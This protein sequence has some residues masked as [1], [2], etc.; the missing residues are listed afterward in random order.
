MFQQV[1]AFFLTADAQPTFKNLMRK[2]TDLHFRT[3]THHQL[4]PLLPTENSNKTCSFSINLLVYTVGFGL[5]DFFLVSDFRCLDF[6]QPREA[7]INSA[8]LRTM[9]QVYTFFNIAVVKM[10]KM[11]N[12]HSR[13]IQPIFLINF[14]AR[15]GKAKRHRFPLKPKVCN[16]TE[17]KYCCLFYI[18][19]L[20]RERKWWI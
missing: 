20:P 12:V 19:R 5:F 6:R 13:T 7:T 8:L 1:V 3:E 14:H 15:I 2:N 16:T 11:R 4:A 17:C 9:R 10:Y 18:P